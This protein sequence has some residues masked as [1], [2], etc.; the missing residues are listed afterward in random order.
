M[1]YKYDD[2]RSERAKIKK[3]SSESRRRSLKDDRYDRDHERYERRDEDG[4][5]QY[6]THHGTSEGSRDR[7]HSPDKAS[8]TS[9]HEF[10]FSKHRYSFNKIFFR[11]QTYIKR[12]VFPHA[13]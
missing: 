6:S 10:Q 8:S 5:S 11:D 2:R 13:H 4:R 1:S 3:R 12:C 7:R 9:Q